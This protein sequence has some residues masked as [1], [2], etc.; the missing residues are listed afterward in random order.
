L[1]D[2]GTCSLRANRAQRIFT[3]GRSRVF[4]GQ[5]AFSFTSFVL[6]TTRFGT[7]VFFLRKTNSKFA[8][9]TIVGRMGD[10]LGLKIMML[11]VTKTVVWSSAQMA[12]NLLYRYCFAPMAL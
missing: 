1:R 4:L 6:H 12:Q 3:A 9:W 2:F 5:A 7:F 11:F 10:E 8:Q